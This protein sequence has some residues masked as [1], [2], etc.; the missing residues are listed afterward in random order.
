M[1][2]IISPENIAERIKDGSTVAVS[3][4]VGCGCPEELLCA[5]EN[6]FIKKGRPKDL[7]IVYAAGQGDG[8]DRGINHLAYEGLVKRVIGG[9]WGLAPKMAKLAVDN[10]IEA[11]NFPQGIITNL[12]RDIAAKKPGTVSAVGLHTF[13]DPRLS[14][15]KVNERTKQDLVEVIELGGKEWLFYQAFQIDVALIRGTSA[16]MSGNISV[17]REAN[18]ID[19]LAIAQAAH[20]CGGIVIAQVERIVENKTLKPWMVKVPGILVDYVVVSKPGNHWQTFGQEY[21][22]ALSGEIRMPLDMIA[23]MPLDERKVISRRAFKEI[24]DDDA[25]N[26][27]IGLPEGISSVASEK[28][29]FDRMHLSIES[30]ITGGLPAGGLNFGSSYNPDSIIDQPSQFDFYD[31]GGLDIAFLGMAQADRFGNVNVSKFNNRLVGCGGFINISQNTKK[32]VFCGTFNSGALEVEVSSGKLK[33]LNEGKHK[34]FIDSVEQI[35]FSGD[36][37]KL[38]H[39]DVLYITERAVFKLTDRGL[40]LTEIA[41]GID[42]KNQVIGQMGFEP[43]VSPDLKLMD[44]EIFLDGVFKTVRK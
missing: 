40:M 7:T 32:V 42:V 27:G 8:R 39:Q 11:Y 33:I 37:A 19:A 30:G 3:G 1:V 12:Y 10:K 28:G 41:P 14:G 17:E 23:P 43:V 15:A 2:E 24:N 35:T 20:N 25:V 4:F 21:D 5:V 29:L 18:L 36:Y 38:K 44:S 6:K 13:V 22:P 16:D 34:K 26:L 31:G 9:H